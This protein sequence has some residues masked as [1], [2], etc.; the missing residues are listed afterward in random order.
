MR[1][2]FAPDS[3]KGTLDAPDA[4]A[5]LAEGWRAARPYDELL[6]APMADG[7]EGT[8]RAMVEAAGG[9]Y[10]DLEVCGPML[11]PVRARYG[12]IDSGLTAVIEM[13]AASGLVLVPEAR[14]DPRI[15]TTRGTGEL[16]RDALDRGCTKLIIGIGGS[17]TN[18]GGAGMAQALGYRLF[19]EAGAEL[20]PGGAPLARL[21]RIDA[22][23]A[24]PRIKACALFAACDV[25]NRLC[26]PQGASAVYGPQKGA[27]HGM[28][29][30]LDAALARLAEIAARDL[31]VR[32]REI[33]GGGAGGGIAA[34]LAAFAHAKLVPGATLVAD[35]IGLRDKLRGA[36]W[37]VTGEGRLDAQTASG[38][39]PAVAAALAREA[40]ARVLAIAGSAADTNAPGFDAIISLAAEH[41]EA[42]AMQETADCLRESVER[43]ARRLG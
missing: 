27:T 23:A 5:A 22:T 28:V 14:R 3:F 11:E 13:A 43:W 19:D 36:D 25:V 33:Q 34:G 31:H 17:A 41:G 16:M 9:A 7:G 32:M 30:E 4:A 38:K 18:D 6:L 24:H 29:Q 20:P 35:A 40:G 39:A 21:D 2:V 1:V 15:A 26:G 37:L 42:R 10:V 8:V 12:L